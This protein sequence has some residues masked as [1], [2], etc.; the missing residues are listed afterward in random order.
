MNYLRVYLLTDT[1]Q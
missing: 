1:E